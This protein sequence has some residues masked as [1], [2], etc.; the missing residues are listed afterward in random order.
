M[1]TVCVLI[2]TYNRK[3]LL[4]NL[5]E[6]L[7]LQSY[8][9]SCV[10]VIDNNSLDG[11][12]N[13]LSELGYIKECIP[14]EIVCNTIA[15]WEFIY[16][17][18]KENTGGS[19]GFAKAFDLAK[20]LPYD[21]IWAMDDD[22]E[23]EAECL[24]TMMKYLT[25]EAQMVIPC[26]GDNNFKDYAIQHYNL[27]NPFY[28]RVNQRKRN[29]ILFSEINEPYVVVEDMAFEGPLMTRKLVQKIGIPDKKYFIL[30][31]DTDYAQR[32]SEV[33]QIRYVR[34]AFLKK[35]IVP[36]SSVKWSWKSY[37]NFRNSVYFE[38][39]YGK[40][41]MVKNISPLLRLFVLLAKSVLTYNFHRIKWLVRGYSDGIHSRMGRTYDPSEIN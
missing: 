30:F 34:K 33:T 16:L 1:R 37:Y 20:D 12:S 4:R 13:M 31:D 41:W 3:D 18:N 6:H 39:K 14:G 24:N 35:M 25:D 15:N 27:N 2:I 32:A 40:N 17:K 9:I 10:L 19:G 29:K 7:K 38:R 23:P 22:V 8:P 5:L 26:R 21:V 28:F 36:D 11:T